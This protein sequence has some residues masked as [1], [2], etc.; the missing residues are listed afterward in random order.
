MPLRLLLLLVLACFPLATY[1]ALDDEKQT[2][3]QELFPKATDIRD[4]LPDY[5]VYPVYQL[6]ELI[7][8]AYE[9]RD[10]SPLQ[11]F[12]GK[13]VSMLIGLDSRGRFTGIRILNHHEP[14][15][16]HGLGEEPLFEFIDQYEGRSLTEQIIIDTS[17]SRSGKSPDGNVVHFDGVS[18]ATVSVLIINDTVLSSALKVARKK[19]E[20]FTQAPA[21]RAKTD[22]YQPLSWAQLIERGYIGH[23]RISSAAI[24]QKLGSPLVDYPE[25]SQP[26]PGEPFAE[27]FFGYINAPM[28]GRNLLGDEG[29]QR[30]KEKTGP[31]AQILAVMSRGLYPHLPD[32]FTPGSSPDRLGLQQNSLSLD[33]RDINVFDQNIQINADGMPEFARTTLFR[34]GGNAGFNPG[35]EAT[36][37]LGV[38][39]RKNHLVADSTELEIPM[40]F[41]QELFEAVEVTPRPEDNRQPVWIGLWKERWLT[42]SLLVLSLTLL[43]VF[44]ARQRT[45]SQYPK[46]V[47][48]F[49]WG[50]L[51][52]TLF[53]IGFYAQGQLSVVNIYTLF[54]AIWDGFSLNVFLMDP[55]LFILWTYTFI[56][57]FVWGRGL[58]CGWLCP[59]GALQE[60]AAWLGEKLK[61]RQV[62]VPEKWH[63][64]L[65][66]LKYP[67]LLVLVG[68]AFYS[69]ELAE[70]LVEVE[71]FKTGI[72]LFFV[73]YWPFVGYAVGLLVVGMFIHKF[74]CRYLCP[75]GAGLAVLGK[76]RLFS[77]LDRV[78]LCGKP[79]QHCKNSCGI[80]AIHKDGRI[81]Y[82][83]CIQCLECVVILKD[84]S[85]CVDKVLEKKRQRQ[86]QILATDAG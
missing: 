71:P 24:E 22:L 31:D 40:A 86:A 46:L 12:A 62:K 38:T 32:D 60:M 67:I 23:W 53:F 83:E 5:P 1:G 77:W 42:I 63:R 27:L 17:G 21:T 3:I 56:S 45:L 44:F 25:A 9:S 59:F 34:V 81:D 75:L 49:R 30:L 80:N 58:F 70:K 15:F 69:L 2:L 50:F 51:F 64:R 6:Q 72:T 4:R 66:L 74:Y 52:F 16:L 33:I 78:E 84:Q 54:L 18:K 41:A 79:C 39:L 68:T 43:T 10:I 26:D 36:L 85:Q 35:A 8:Y 55:V 65:I 28:V 57:L 48:R 13:P 19:L 37:K 14:V 20:G 11:G 61:L 29:F 7:G 73:R 47:H 76:L 82:N